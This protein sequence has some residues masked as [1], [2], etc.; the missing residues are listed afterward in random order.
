M[1]DANLAALLYLIASVCFILA[2]KGLSHPDTSR[3]GNLLGMIGMAI[4]VFTTLAVLPE[5]GL[6]LVTIFVGVLIGGI[7][8]C[9]S[10]MARGF[11]A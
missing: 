2:L 6:N 5:L 9:A 7:L 11:G 1:I 3:R 10:L 8:I 4:A